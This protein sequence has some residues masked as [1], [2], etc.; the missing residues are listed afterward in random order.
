MVCPCDLHLILMSVSVVFVFRVWLCMICFVMNIWHSLIMFLSFIQVCVQLVYLKRYYAWYVLSFLC[1]IYIIS[2]DLSCFLKCS[3]MSQQQGYIFVQ[4][5]HILSLFQIDSMKSNS[6]YADYVL[7]TCE[8][9]ERIVISNQSS[10]LILN[11][12]LFPFLLVSLQSLELNS[13]SF[14]VLK[15]EKEK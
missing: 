6:I 4:I 5:P 15:T 14:P 1:D 10:S 13:F 12:P 7:E 9:A 8:C 2:M 11:K 3:A